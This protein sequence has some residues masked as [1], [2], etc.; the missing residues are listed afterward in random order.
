[1]SSFDPM[2]TAID[3]LDAYRAADLNQLIDLYAD[4]AALECGNETVVIGR[5]AISAYWRRRFETKPAGKLEDLL[6]AGDAIV[7]S[8]HL[9]SGLGHTTM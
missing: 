9:P 2:A 8:Y 7:V 5:E 6:S 1:M 3:W 4:D